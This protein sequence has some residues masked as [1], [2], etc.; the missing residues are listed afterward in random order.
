MPNA[1]DFIDIIL[2][3]TQR[4]TP[5]IIHKHFAISRIRE[6]YMRK[7]RFTQQNIHDKLS[8][9]LEE[10]PKLDVRKTKTKQ[11]RIEEKI[12]S[13]L[14]KIFKKYRIFIHFMQ[15]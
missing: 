13:P 11:R 12:N 6:F 5:T 2:S 15:I 4:K 8:A 9:I 1:P 10:F 7:V 3:K 14:K